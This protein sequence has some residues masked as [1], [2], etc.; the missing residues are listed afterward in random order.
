MRT[1][2][3]LLVISPTIFVVVVLL[4]ACNGG[5]QQNKNTAKEIVENP[6]NN[7]FKNAYAKKRTLYDLIRTPE[8]KEQVVKYYS[9]EF[10]KK[11]YEVVE[12]VVPISYN[13]TE[14][15]YVCSGFKAHNAG[16]TEATVNYDAKTNGLD[17]KLIIDGTRIER[18]GEIDYGNWKKGYYKDDF[19]EDILKQPFIQTDIRGTVRS[20]DCEL[21]I[22]F[23][24]DEGIRLWITGEYCCYDPMK[25]FIKI[26]DNS[27]NE[28]LSVPIDNIRKDSIFIYN[29]KG[30]LMLLAALKCGNTTIS[31]KYNTALDNDYLYLFQ[32]HGPT[33][34]ENAIKL[35][36]NEI[37]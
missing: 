30:L 27:T 16:I 12:V 34:I 1:K 7:I 15:I 9:L 4:F 13:S 10:Y 37:M 2:Y 33:Q 5:H 32:I 6:L 31:I 25:A 8:F 24:F 3:H 23:N 28:T 11:M 17:I 36:E 21:H 26:R 14:D 29:E 19:G 18:S 35:I 22:R 20:F